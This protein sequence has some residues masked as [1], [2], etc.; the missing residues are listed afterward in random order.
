VIAAGAEGVFFLGAGEASAYVNN[1]R[2]IPIT[3]TSGNALMTL[4]AI[5]V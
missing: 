1:N 4:M 5:A 2:Q 3:Y